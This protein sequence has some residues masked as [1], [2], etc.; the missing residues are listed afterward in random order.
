MRSA[1]GGAVAYGG[2][3]TAPG[4]V[5]TTGSFASD[6][7]K[8]VIGELDG[9]LTPRLQSLAQTLGTSVAVDVTNNIWGWLWSKLAVNAQ[10]NAIC[11]LTGLATD[12]IATDQP[13][14]RL[15]LAMAD[16]TIAVAT[17]LGLTL[18]PALIWG[19]AGAPLRITT[20]R[21]LRVLEER[22]VNRWNA[23]TKPS[24]LQDAEKGRPTEIDALNGFIV[25]KANALNIPAPINAA[26][27]ALVKRREGDA[28]GFRHEATRK[29]LNTIYQEAF[30]HRRVERRRSRPASG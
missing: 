8:L 27:V 22:F 1:I 20:D 23:P 15:S 16:E 25:A 11:A 29:Q 17:E 24:M 12:G 30:E 19:D 5:K 21:V 4:R 26:I 3:L 28:S 14:R 10:M 13:L 7:A 9:S 18:D 6:A 2:E